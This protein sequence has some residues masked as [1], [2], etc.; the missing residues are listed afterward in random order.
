MIKA[1]WE[2]I[3][4]K[5]KFKIRK[6]RTNPEVELALNLII[7]ICIIC[8]FYSF[9][10][11]EDP[12]LPFEIFKSYYRSF[13]RIVGLFGAIILTIYKFRYQILVLLDLAEYDDY[14]NARK[15][16]ELTEEQK[17]YR[18]KNDRYHTSIEFSHYDEGNKKY[19]T[20]YCANSGMVDTVRNL[21]EEI[22]SKFNLPI[23]SK[24][25]D[26]NKTTYVLLKYPNKRL[27]LPVK[28]KNNKD[29]ILPI[30]EDIEW[31]LNN[32]PH[33]L[34]A[35]STGGG[36]TYFLFYLLYC[37]LSKKIDVY[38]CDPKHSD[39]F[40][41]RRKLKN[42]NF[43]CESSPNRMAMNIR[44]VKEFMLERYKRIDENGKIG[45]VYSDLSLKPIILMV[46]EFGSFLT[47]CDSNTKKEVLANLRQIIFQGRQAGV[48]VILSTQK[49]DAD[50][51]P[52]DIRDQ[53]GLRAVLGNL[54]KEGYRM[55][56]GSN[57]QD[58]YQT[59]ESGS[60]YIYLDTMNTSI[61]IIFKAPFIEDLASITDYID[62]SIE[63]FLSHSFDYDGELLEERPA[64]RVYPY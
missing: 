23:I 9:F 41:A 3:K 48:F 61:P 64:P 29:H 35:G 51:I 14:D 37:F 7:P 21:D 5:E 22:K 53:L 18:D 42:Y 26:L 43:Y 45:R 58:S 11:K 34:I 4:P 1:F 33:A 31:N 46:D 47:S 32:N 20:A 54:T 62:S 24:I 6:I 25:E 15:L 63:Y 50:T 44:K 38:V 49:P 40:M 60:G 52:T 8:F 59:N 55:V 30:T 28:F 27:S 56:F 17:L 39:L 19:V 57:S 13:L 12:F 2:Y 16:Y 36:K 10:I